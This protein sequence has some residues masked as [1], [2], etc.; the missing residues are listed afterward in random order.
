MPMIH[1]DPA[2][3]IEIVLAAHKDRPADKRPVFIAHPPTV[4]EALKIDRL[5]STLSGK[6][7]EEQNGMYSELLN[8]CLCGWRNVKKR[9]GT[10]VPFSEA[11]MLDDVLSAEQ[12]GELVVSAINLRKLKEESSG[13]S[14]SQSPDAGAASAGVAAL[15][16]A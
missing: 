5:T 15:D 11:A 16:A 7:A 10:E 13:E 2:D 1:L 14:D 8:L 6:T 12:K 3:E 9:D 4:I